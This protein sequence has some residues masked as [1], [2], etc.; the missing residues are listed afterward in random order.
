MLTLA[1]NEVSKQSSLE[2]LKNAYTN[3][4]VFLDKGTFFVGLQSEVGV[5]IL[6]WGETVKKA[7]DAAAAKG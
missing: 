5:Q 7:V 6:G 2:V 3:L 4:T 1:T